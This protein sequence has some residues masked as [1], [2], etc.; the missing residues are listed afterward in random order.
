MNQIKN[1]ASSIVL[2]TAAAL[3]LRI[4]SRQSEA[5]P[6]GG[7]DLM[8]P[9]FPPQVSVR[10]ENGK[11]IIDSNGI[12]NH[13]VGKFPRRGNPNTIAPQ[14]YHFEVP[15]EPRIADKPTLLTMQAF[16]VAVNGIVF[17]PNAAEWWQ[18]DY[19]W[20]YE[21]NAG[22]IDLGLDANGAHV[23]PNGAYHYHSIPSGLMKK[24][25]PENT[26]KPTLVGWAADG[27]PI[28]ARWDHADPK[29]AKSTAREMKSSYRVKQGNRP[30]GPGGK[31]DGTYLAD[32]EYVS[33]S[34]DLDECGGRFGVTPE[35]PEGIY[36]YVLTDD[37]PFI[38]R[39]YKGTPDVSFQRR[40]P[41]PG[42]RGGPGGRR[43]P[44]PGGGGPPP[45]GFPPPR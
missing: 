28:Y 23:Q 36:H 34:G 21:A 22:K 38:P 6:A 10:S 13:D 15:L 32:Y 25:N 27:F 16:G 8:P 45:P 31:F 37:Y 12:P 11:R 18:G 35:N 26:A 42:G 30:G 1:L 43:G 19:S 40:G 29:D 9:A 39:I 3:A 14:R 5:A 41:P 4:T 17:D 24:L 33:G 44:P 7:S 20:Q 2:F